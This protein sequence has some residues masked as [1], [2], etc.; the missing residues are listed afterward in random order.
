LATKKKAKRTARAPKSTIPRSEGGTWKQL[1]ALRALTQE[2]GVVHEAQAM[3]L[4]YWGPLALPHCHDIE[5][6]VQLPYLA[7]DVDDKGTVTSSLMDANRVEYR[8]LAKERPPKNLPK[9]LEGLCRS[10]RALLGDYFDVGVK[11]NGAA[12][13]VRKGSPK[14]KTDMTKLITRLRGIDGSDE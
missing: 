10:V 12:I 14:P 3:Q 4:K 2:M 7:E 1:M 6:R 11:I 13:F 8:A 9:L 5:V